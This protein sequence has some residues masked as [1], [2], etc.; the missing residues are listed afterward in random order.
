MKILL[1]GARGQL[2]RDLAATGQAAGHAMLARTHAELDIRDAA[3]LE[4]QVAAERPDA[5]VSTAA[6]RRVET[7]ERQPTVH[8]PRCCPRWDV[9][10]APSRA[11]APTAAAFLSTLQARMPF[12]IRAVQV[13][14]GSELAAAFEQACQQLG[15]RLFVL[16]RRPQAQR[17]RRTRQ[18]HPY[19]G[20]P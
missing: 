2:G 3:A 18:P 10:E 8:R 13:D 15:L 17:P 7:C 19:R 1:I 14:G 16:P 20:V 4:A 11:A 9:L 6:F 12:S 5:V